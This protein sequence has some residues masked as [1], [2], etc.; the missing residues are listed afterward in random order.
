MLKKPL[1][2]DPPSR[3]N[4]SKFAMY[5]IRN[6]INCHENLSINCTFMPGLF[7]CYEY[8]L[9]ILERLLIITQLLHPF[10]DVCFCN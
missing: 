5:R 9:N 3:N 10:I 2:R 7:Y 1:R 4:F 6:E 8:P